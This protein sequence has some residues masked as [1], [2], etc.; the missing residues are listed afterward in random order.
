MLYIIATPIGN[1]DDISKRALE[2]LKSVDLI[3]AEDTRHTRKLLSHYDISTKLESFHGDSSPQKVEK[4]LEFITK[5]TTIALV[6][7]AGTP[8]ISDPGSYLIEEIHKAQ[9]NVS[10]IP[11][12]G[13]SAV[14]AALSVSGFPADSYSFWG[15]PPRK[16]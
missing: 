5:D 12:P 6:T 14:A 1:L 3:L 11:I 9:L 13:P 7:D 10:I 8:A 2:A 15:Y 4:I 16:N